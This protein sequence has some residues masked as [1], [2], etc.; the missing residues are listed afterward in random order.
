MWIVKVTILLV[1]LLCFSNKIQLTDKCCND[2]LCPEGCVRYMMILLLPHGSHQL[3]GYHTTNGPQQCHRRTCHR[4]PGRQVGNAES[5]KRA[6]IFW[7]HKVLSTIYFCRRS[8]TAPGLSCGHRKQ[9]CRC[10]GQVW[11]LLL[12]GEIIFCWESSWQ[13]RSFLGNY[14]NNFLFL[15]QFIADSNLDWKLNSINPLQYTDISDKSMMQTTTTNYLKYLLFLVRWIYFTKVF[16]R[17]IHLQ[18]F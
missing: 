17:T 16:Y 14:S 11:W 7:G 2:H 8:V 1:M 9:D 6:T 12:G 4:E 5:I 10:G 3:P 13:N 18:P 15:S